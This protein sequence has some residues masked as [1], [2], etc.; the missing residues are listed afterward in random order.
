MPFS[1]GSLMHSTATKNASRSKLGDIALWRGHGTKIRVPGV[2]AVHGH[3]GRR[4][5]PDVPKSFTP[6]ATYD[7]KTLKFNA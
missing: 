6:S 3:A 1:E 4:R 2:A 5:T 7:P